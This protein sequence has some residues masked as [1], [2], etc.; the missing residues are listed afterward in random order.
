MINYTH[1]PHSSQFISVSPPLLAPKSSAWVPRSRRSKNHLRKRLPLA[2]LGFLRAV[3]RRRPEGAPRSNTVVHFCLPAHF[4]LQRRVVTLQCRSEG[5]P[6]VISAV[7]ALATQWSLRA[8]MSA[9]RPY[10]FC[11]VLADVAA[12]RPSHVVHHLAGHCAVLLHAVK[13]LALQNKGQE[14]LY[15]G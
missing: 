6:C 5:A 15:Q 2:R 11:H 3:A 9:L 14:A 7:S 10:A 8:Y 1:F 13:F 4:S 12:P